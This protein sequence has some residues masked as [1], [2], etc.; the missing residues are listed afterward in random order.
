[1]KII[2]GVKLAA[3]IGKRLAAKLNTKYRGVTI[4]MKK[5]YDIQGGFV[6]VVKAITAFGRRLATVLIALPF[7][8]APAFAQEAKGGDTKGDLTTKAT[9]PVGALIQLQLQDLYIPSSNNSSGY[10]NTAIIQPVVPFDLGGESYFQGII[11]RTTMPIVTTPEV[12]DN[13]ETGG[14]TA[15][16]GSSRIFPI[17]AR[18]PAPLGSRP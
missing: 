13:R 6:V 18:G 8:T 14:V 1:M 16:N 4:V 7:L 2:G 9:N 11:T 15:R 10:A 3:A 12:N 5:N 17:S